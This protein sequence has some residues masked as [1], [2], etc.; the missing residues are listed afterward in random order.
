MLCI[1]NTVC[2]NVNLF[3]LVSQQN[4]F[5]KNRF[6]PTPLSSTS[7]ERRR[8]GDTERGTALA[9]P[10]PGRRRTWTAGARRTASYYHGL[11]LLTRKRTS[12]REKRHQHVAEVVPVVARAC[13][14]PP[15]ANNTSWVT[16]HGDAIGSCWDSS[17]KIVSVCRSVLL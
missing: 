7:R 6:Q 10:G 4:S 11:M 8:T 13:M 17:R 16:A 1:V 12:R 14:N 5:R 2:S 3:K 15:S 9:R